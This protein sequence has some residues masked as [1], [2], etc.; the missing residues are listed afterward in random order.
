MPRPSMSEAKQDGLHRAGCRILTNATI[1]TLFHD[2]GRF[3]MPNSQHSPI[4]VWDW[5]YIANIHITHNKSCIFDPFLGSFT[6]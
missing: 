5:I 4:F 3:R 6:Y 2:E 1:F